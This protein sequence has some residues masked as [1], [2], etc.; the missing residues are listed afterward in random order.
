MLLALSIRNLVLI[1]RCDVTF[2]RG[3]TILT[4]ET[5]AGKSMLLDALGLILGD[6][7]DSSFL[8]PYQESLSITACFDGGCT[9]LKDVFADNA[10]KSYSELLI[11][12]TIDVGGR[13]RAFVN[14][15]PVTLHFLKTVGQYALDIHGQFDRF[16][17]MKH[18]LSLLDDYAKHV[19]PESSSAVGYLNLCIEVKKAYQ[20]W[21]EALKEMEALQRAQDSASQRCD[22]LAF[23]IDELLQLDP[24]ENEE[25]HLL[26]ERESFKQLMANAE[27]LKQV[28]KIFDLGVIPHLIQLQKVFGKCVGYEDLHDRLDRIIVDVSDIERDVQSKVAQLDFDPNSFCVLDERLHV[29]RHVARKHRTTVNELHTLSQRL[30]DESASLEH[31]DE[32]VEELMK[33]VANLEKSFAKQAEL[34]HQKRCCAAHALSQA[35]MNELPALKLE[36]AQFKVTVTKQDSTFASEE[37]LDMVELLFSANP[38]VGLQPMGKIASGGELSRLMLAIKVVLSQSSFVETLVFDEIDSGVGGA[39]ATAIGARLKRL[40]KH[41]QVIAITHSPQVA[42]F[43]DHHFKVVKSVVDNQTFVGIEKLEGGR[44]RESELARML[45]GENV[46]EEALKAAAS[47]REEAIFECDPSRFLGP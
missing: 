14:D 24:K 23:D 17:D 13:G 34:L 18:S 12:R 7:F 38:G 42:A 28:M 30:R 15:E 39:T 36:S 46:T 16:T 35:V 31:L 1:D 22:Q 27:G 44:A 32:R 33:T 26:N 19:C 37:G 8:R 4:G 9:G 29:L 43:A 10:L 40:S 47:L 25:D 6:R 20:S 45:S 21:H 5:G 2:D 3:L 11:R 41:H